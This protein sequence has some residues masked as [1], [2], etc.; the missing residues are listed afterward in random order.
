M[1]DWSLSSNHRHH[2]KRNLL[3]L[4]FLLRVIRIVWGILGRYAWCIWIMIDCL[5]IIWWGCISWRRW[6]WCFSRSCI[7]D[8]GRIIGDWG[9]DYGGLIWGMELWAFCLEIRR[10]DKLWPRKFR[11]SP[12]REKHCCNWVRS[13][14]RNNWRGKNKTLFSENWRARSSED[15]FLKPLNNQSLSKWRNLIRYALINMVMSLAKV[16]LLN[17]KTSSVNLDLRQVIWRSLR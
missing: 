7:L 4:L 10:R 5:R 14:Y 8:L 11:A 1:I 3:L 6:C 12:R 13:K 17:G 15:Q 2:R 16:Y 9:W